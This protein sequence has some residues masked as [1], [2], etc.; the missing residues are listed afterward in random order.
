MLAASSGQYYTPVQIQ[1]AMFLLD[2]QVPEIFDTTSRFLFRPYDY[3]PF[4]A[5]VYV[6]IERLEAEG[7][8]ETAINSTRAMKLYAASPRGLEVVEPLR[9]Q[10]TSVQLAF[11]D[12]AS[13][14]VRSLSFS[15][16]VSAIYEAYPE[17]RKNSIFV[18]R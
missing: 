5:D 2:R 7:L 9:G 6:E 13:A 17:M 18:D 14:F 10:L 4:D 3:G 12:R 15:D 16:L 8:A 11:I 1:K